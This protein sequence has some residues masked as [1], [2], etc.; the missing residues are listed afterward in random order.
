MAQV[1]CDTSSTM[2][3]PRCL[4]A[5]SDRRMA[6]SVMLQLSELICSGILDAEFRCI[7]YINTSTRSSAS[8]LDKDGF[9]TPTLWS[10]RYTFNPKIN[11]VMVVA[12]ISN[13]LGTQTIVTVIQRTG[14]TSRPPGSTYPEPTMLLPRIFCPMSAAI[15]L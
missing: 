2:T 7:V 11:F 12:G 10:A 4:L 6:P 5:V 3:A 14:A 9:S 15:A 8:S 1:K 13:I